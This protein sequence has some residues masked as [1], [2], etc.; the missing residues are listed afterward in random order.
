MPK[1]ASVSHTKLLKLLN[2]AGCKV[3]NVYGHQRMAKFVELVSGGQQTAYL[4]ITKSYELVWP[5]NIKQLY[6][7]SPAYASLYARTQSVLSRC[8]GISVT[9][10][11][12]ITDTQAWALLPGYSKAGPAPDFIETIEKS[13]RLLEQESGHDILPD[14]PVAPPTRAPSGAPS[15]TGP[16]QVELVDP[17]GQP[18]EEVFSHIVG[19]RGPPQPVVFPQIE[20]T[21]RLSFEM[22][23]LYPLITLNEF[24]NASASFERFL[25]ERKGEC[26]LAEKAENDMAFREI[27]MKLAKLRD[28]MISTLA[29]LQAREVDLV[30]KAK[31][32]EGVYQSSKT[33]SDSPVSL[34]Q[35]GLRET[36]VQTTNHLRTLNIEIT[37]SRE[38]IKRQIR[39]YLEGLELLLES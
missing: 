21:E 19:P 25:A 24:H 5:T 11:L 9:G 18:I 33:F 14:E 7:L 27:E 28:V 2:K 12:L 16:S 10:E 1:G 26:T 4:V 29:G 13:I 15:G 35:K 39:V 37:Q 32:L 3:G 22:G 36:M 38:D 31:K 34:N 20:E 8:K 23:V 6:D 30:A 17:F